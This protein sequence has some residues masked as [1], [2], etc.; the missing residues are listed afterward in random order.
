MIQEK[1]HSYGPR[2]HLQT[3]PGPGGPLFGAA[4]DRETPQYLKRVVGHH[5]DL[6]IFALRLDLGLSSEAVLGLRWEVRGI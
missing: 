2:V 6:H 3:H 1:P 5:P 4:P